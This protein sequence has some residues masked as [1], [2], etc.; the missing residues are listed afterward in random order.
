VRYAFPTAEDI[1][2]VSPEECRAI[3]FSRQKAL[4]LVSLARA[5]EQGELD[6]EALAEQDDE[7]MIR[8]RLLDVHGIGR[9]TAEY[10][11]LRGL[12]R[13]DVFPGDD[14]GAQK[15]LA[16]WLGRSRR[17]DYAGV[18]RAVKQSSPFAGL[19]YFHLLLD[20]LSR[21]RRLEPTNSSSVRVD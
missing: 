4:A 17:P 21:A 1:A 19:V 15:A 10:V 9:W 12:G 5:I 16:R 20:G 3:G 7:A 11:L 2:R 13:L 14:V 6:L 8:Q 18:G